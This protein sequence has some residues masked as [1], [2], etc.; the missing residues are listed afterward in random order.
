MS[1]YFQGWLRKL[2]IDPFLLKMTFVIILFCC[3]TSC[4]SEYEESFSLKI[5][6]M[7]T[8][9]NNMSGVRI[10]FANETDNTT[11]LI[12]NECITN[13]SGFVQFHNLR[14]GLYNFYNITD[15]LGVYSDSIK[16]MVTN[17]METELKLKLKP[18]LHTKGN[19]VLKIIDTS[20][21]PRIGLSVQLYNRKNSI[22]TY[23]SDNKT[24][25]L[26]VIR[27][28][29]LDEGIY[30]LKIDNKE[31]FSGLIS[32]AYT[33]NWNY[34]D[35]FYSVPVKTTKTDWK[36]VSF[37]TQ[38]NA[39]TYAAK[40]AIDEDELTFWNTSWSIV[41]RPIHP[42]ILTIDMSKKQSFKGFV[43]RN[44]LKSSG[45]A[46]FKD[47]EIFISD[48]LQNWQSVGVF[49]QKDVE[50]DQFYYLPIVV[51]SR[52]FK[53][54]TISQWNSNPATTVTLAEI[55]VFN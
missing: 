5:H 48:D 37:S 34:I 24:D 18:I 6:V 36:I 27:Y 46:A 44:S 2:S 9:S 16:V 35:L 28:Y 15:G 50:G 55:G 53:L 19:A 51:S 45:G 49:Q 25:I 20:G 22:D 42:H 12:I 47:F 14:A 43:L 38:E 1:Q 40:N 39:T 33:T 10:G 8:L 26:G 41:P 23:I 17:D 54:S 11:S 3:I 30:I 4:K 29:N 31:C 21:N 32:P 7:D 13:D 52:Y